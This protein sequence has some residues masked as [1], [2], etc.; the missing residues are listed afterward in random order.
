MNELSEMGLASSS[1]GQTQAPGGPGPAQGQQPG[2]SWFRM[3]TEP[4]DAEPQDAE[5]L[6]SAP[7]AHKV[8]RTAHLPSSPLSEMGGSLPAAPHGWRRG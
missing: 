4:L 6:D 8:P 5:P 7:R 3:D 1:E 2:K